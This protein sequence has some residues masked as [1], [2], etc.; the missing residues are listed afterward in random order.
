VSENG[1]DA[2]MPI[3]CHLMGNMMNHRILGHHILRQPHM[4]FNQQMMTYCETILAVNLVQPIMT[5]TQT[6]FY[7]SGGNPKV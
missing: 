4:G 2:R 3:N 7:G 5:N 1:V 6:S